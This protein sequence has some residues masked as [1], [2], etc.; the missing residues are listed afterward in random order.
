MNWVTDKILGAIKETRYVTGTYPDYD[1]A[2]KDYYNSNG[3]DWVIFPYTDMVYI[4]YPETKQ[5]LCVSHTHGQVPTPQKQF[6]SYLLKLPTLNLN[7]LNYLTTFYYR[8]HISSEKDKLFNSFSGKSALMNTIC[9]DTYGRI[10]FDYQLAYLYGLFAGCTQK[11][12]WKWVAEMEKN[13]PEAMVDAI[14]L[15]VTGEYNLYELWEQY[16]LNE[17]IFHPQRKGAERLWQYI[18]SFNKIG[19]LIEHIS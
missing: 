6:K 17:Q 4:D 10:V 3:Y 15:D 16:N 12:A 5:V 13:T 9:Q 11:E 19:S 2:L 14:S 1:I 8:R 18:Q 7:S